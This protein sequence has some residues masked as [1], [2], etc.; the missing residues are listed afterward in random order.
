[1]LKIRVELTNSSSDRIVEF[2]GWVGGGDMIA[3]GVTQLLGTSELGKAVQSASPTASLV[4]NIG[5]PYKQVPT[6]SVFGAK[7]PG[8]ADLALRPAES[9]QSELV[10]P[11]PLDTVEYLRLELSPAAYGGNEPLRWQIPKAAFKPAA[12]PGT[13]P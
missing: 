11:L 6:M 9:R 2:A 5:N 8:A 13:S 7:L 1:M 3:R 4:D 12:A 10:F